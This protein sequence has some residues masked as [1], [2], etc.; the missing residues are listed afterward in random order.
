MFNKNDQAEQDSARSI[1]RTIILKLLFE[2]KSLARY[3]IATIVGLTQGSV[4]RIINECIEAGIVVEENSLLETEARGRRPIPLALNS[5]LYFVIGI[6]IGHFW[7]DMCLMNITGEVLYSS[8]E[9]RPHSFDEAYHFI[10]STVHNLKENSQ[11]FIL[12]IGITLYGKVNNE[13]GEFSDDN[14][15]GWKNITIRS[16]LENEV[17]IP[18]IIDTNVYSMALAEFIHNPLPQDNALLF[19][20]VATTVGMAIVVNNVVIRGKQGLAGMLEH[21]PWQMSGPKCQVCG[22]RGCISALL[23]D[24]TVLAEAHKKYSSE[25][26]PDIYAL[27]HRSHND[28]FLEEILKNRDK[29]VGQ[30]VAT[31]ATFHDPSRIVLSGG[32]LNI[33]WIQRSYEEA[34]QNLKSNY[35]RIETPYSKIDVPFTLI[36]AGTVALR[37]VFSTSLKL[38]T[39][40]DSNNNL[41]KIALIPLTTPPVLD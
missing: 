30:L 1:N 36:G 41:N 8:R 31:L 40:K 24:K 6:H 10:K 35:A 29:K 34:L 39:L 23:S 15:L 22:I 4:T 12:A 5:N 13:T 3:E 32:G 27:V 25:L 28:P 18:I 11:G 21:K 17:R 33:P 14:I 7:I 9:S 19:L 26:I 16:K 38:I 37:K 20:N 2:K